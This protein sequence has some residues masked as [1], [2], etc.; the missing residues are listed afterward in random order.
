MVLTKLN[1]DSNR[2]SMGAFWGS[3]SVVLKKLNTDFHKVST[4]ALS[5]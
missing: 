1:A 2:F 4:G 5:T 3:E